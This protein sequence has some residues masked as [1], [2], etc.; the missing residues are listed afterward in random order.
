MFVLVYRCS[1]Q[2]NY[3]DIVGDPKWTKCLGKKLS[4]MSAVLSESE[5][6]KQKPNGME[7]MTGFLPLSSM[8]DLKAFLS[9][10]KGIEERKAVVSHGKSS[11]NTKLKVT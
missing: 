6:C 9:S 2:K 7:Q 8:E 10:L 5:S 4:E 3:A 1:S 11:W